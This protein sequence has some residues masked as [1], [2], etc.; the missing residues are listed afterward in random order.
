MCAVVEDHEK[1]P[2]LWA[3][4]CAT[5][6]VDRGTHL[7]NPRLPD[8]GTIPRVIDASDLTHL[9]LMDFLQLLVV[10]GVPKGHSNDTLDEF[11]RMLTR[12]R[13]KEAVQKRHNCGRSGSHMKPS[14]RNSISS[15]SAGQFFV[16]V[17]FNDDDCSAY[18][19]ENRTFIQLSGP[20]LHQA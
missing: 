18:V 4:V 17:S 10:V 8:P 14:Y 15:T 5:G 1:L 11:K 3:V 20:G 7:G 13:W 16:V 2:R 6:D 9:V 19:G 12:Y